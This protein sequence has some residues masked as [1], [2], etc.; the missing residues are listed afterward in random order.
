VSD[1]SRLRNKQKEIAPFH[2][3]LKTHYKVDDKLATMLEKDS[4]FY[5]GTLSQL[6]RDIVVDTLSGTRDS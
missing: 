5:G 6:S 2:V 4:K 1:F 3:P